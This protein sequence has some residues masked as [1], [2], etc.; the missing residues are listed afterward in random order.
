MNTKAI[1]AI[2]FILVII[3]LAIYAARREE[4]MP[5]QVVEPEVSVLT[6]PEVTKTE[7]PKDVDGTAQITVQTIPTLE[8]TPTQ[9]PSHGTYEPYDPAKLAQAAEGDVVLFFR[10]P[11]C[12]TCRALD[13]DIRANLSAIPQ[14]VIILDV[15]YDSST[16]LKQKYGVTYQHTLVQVDA[17]GNQI[18]KWTG[19]PTLEN[20]LS[21]IQ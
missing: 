3:G 16:E 9:V 15:D 17:E 21:Q 7:E 14:K 8:A 11:W 20:L 19:S 6:T 13:A 1:P 2:I 4:P 12:P 18:A 5:E 10:A